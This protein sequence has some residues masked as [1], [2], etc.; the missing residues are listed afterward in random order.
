M[1]DIRPFVFWVPMSALIAAVIISLIDIDTLLAVTGA[2]NTWILD[3][4]A[5]LFRWASF[6]FVITV[7]IVFFSPLGRVV[8]GGEGAEPILS[9]WSWFSISLCTTIAI[10]ILFWATAEP[11]FHLSGPPAASGIVAGSAEAV[12]FSM[13]SLFM[14]WT[15]TPY[16]IYTVPG[17]A[18]ALAYYN[19]GK[20]YS[21]SGPLSLVARGAES[22]WGGN[23]ID[24][25]ALFA[26][27][28]G[29][30]ATLGAG[31]LS[32]AGGI[33][34]V[35]GI[36][37][38]PL[39]TAGVTIT[40]V[41][42]FVIS[43]ITGLQ[44]G[45]RILSDINAKFFF[46]LVLFIFAAGPTAFILEAGYSGLVDYASTFV[47]RSLGLGADYDN[48]WSKSWT[49]F[50]VANW[51]AWAPIAGLFL[52]RIARGYTVRA[53]ILV[54]FIGPSFFGMAWMSIFG[55]AAMHIDQ[56]E[57]GVLS[58]AL[59]EMGPEA[60]IYLVIDRYPLASLISIVFI[61]LSF[62]S[63][64][65]AADSNT[66]AIASVCRKDSTP[67]NMNQMADAPTDRS[68]LI[69]KVV[70]A[71]FIGTTAWVM[72]AFTGVDGVRTLSNLGG[73]PALFIVIGLN[74][75]VLKLVY[76]SVKGQ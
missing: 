66:E 28:A 30:A 17:I 18:C 42:A 68:S 2:A 48:E 9:R 32:L 57:S 33:A 60:I 31:T 67:E 51:L 76:R 13:S 52:G 73:F 14:H 58:T 72:T 34:D 35:S 6:G 41:S 74:I 15:F 49:V 22:H 54:N 4:F 69:L 70:L 59:T 36:R 50:Y 24:A 27:F 75:A 8:I 53:F 21:L 46:A 47:P 37:V 38:T 71:V 55:G 44:R 11:L 5:F 62:I 39:L 12:T 43:S 20:S 25:V 61:F 7:L 23:I 19:L 40:V 64:V 29:I 65:T 16:A 10:G 1:K 3:E 26:L 56:T 63:Y 45:I